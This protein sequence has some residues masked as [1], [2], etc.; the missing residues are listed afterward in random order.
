MGELWE[1][2][3][4]HD[5][6][7]ENYKYLQMF[8]QVPKKYTA[9]GEKERG[10]SRCKCDWRFA[11]TQMDGSST[12]AHIQSPEWQQEKKKAEYYIFCATQTEGGTLLS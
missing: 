7:V 1:R 12:W 2:S 8:I 6:E 3:Q 4:K 10:N 9:G 11:R 5:G